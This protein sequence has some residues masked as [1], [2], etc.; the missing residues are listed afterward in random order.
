MRENTTNSLIMIQPTLLA[1]SFSGPPVPVL[2]DVTSIAPDRI[3]LLDTFFQ[4]I[5]FHGE[6]ISAWRKQGY[7]EDA[8]HTNFR[9]LLTAPKEARRCCSPSASPCP[10]T[11]SATSTARRRAS[12]SRSST[13]R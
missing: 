3:L 9:E 8:E 12:S 2:L 4:V 10:C 13:R 7:H 6:T 5:V 11:S 1:Y